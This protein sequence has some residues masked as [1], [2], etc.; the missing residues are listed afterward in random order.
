[1]HQLGIHTRQELHCMPASDRN[2]WA[3]FFAEEP[4]GF[5]ADN[6]RSGTVAAV[7]INFLLQIKPHSALTPEHIFPSLKPP[8]TPEDWTPVTPQAFAD[9]AAQACTE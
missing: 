7:L 2:N 3:L 9:F 8:E 6:W 4:A 5:A 1:M